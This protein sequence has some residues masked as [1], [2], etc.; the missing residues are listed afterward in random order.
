[1]WVDSKDVLFLRVEFGRK[2]QGGLHFTLPPLV[3]GE[4]ES[5]YRRV[6]PEGEE[7]REDRSSDLF[8]ENHTFRAVAKGLSQ[9]A[10]H[11]PPL[12]SDPSRKL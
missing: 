2:D 7:E 1:M 3:D 8:G 11:R 5:V 12:A 9:A 10:T 6:W 4:P